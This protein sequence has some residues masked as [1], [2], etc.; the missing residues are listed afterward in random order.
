MSQLPEDD[1]RYSR[2]GFFAF[3]ASR[4]PVGTELLKDSGGSAPVMSQSRGRVLAAARPLLLA[5]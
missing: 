3:I 4:Q 5:A 2:T 1:V